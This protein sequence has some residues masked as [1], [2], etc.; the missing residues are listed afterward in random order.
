MDLKVQNCV[1]MRRRL[2]LANVTVQASGLSRDPRRKMRAALGEVVAAKGRLPSEVSSTT[3]LAS[4]RWGRTG[5]RPGSGLA[6]PST[7]V[8]C[9]EVK[10]A[11]NLVHSDTGTNLIYNLRSSL[12]T[13]TK[14]L[15]LQAWTVAL[16]NLVATGLRAS[17]HNLLSLQDQEQQA[18]S[19]PSPSSGLQG[20]PTSAPAEHD[21][22]Q[23]ESDP[24]LQLTPSGK[25]GMKLCRRPDSSSCRLQ[26]G[27]VK[28][29][30]CMAACSAQWCPMP[31]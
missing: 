7:P 6:S 9:P 27:A 5:V 29:V 22:D 17:P 8:S 10:Q 31:N 20:P 21:W 24:A 18:A 19:T 23:D 12:E 26:Q 30:T 13:A 16:P 25:T 15:H 3:L 11:R 4:L 1:I 28:N 14:M 2:S